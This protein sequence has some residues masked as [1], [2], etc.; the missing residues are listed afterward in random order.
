ML[1]IVGMKKRTKFDQNQQRFAYSGL[2][3]V[4]YAIITFRECKA[5]RSL[6]MKK[7]VLII[8]V[9]K[10]NSMNVHK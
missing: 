10:K 1:V 6:G 2:K 8:G 5:G 3:E 7:T 9:G 4:A